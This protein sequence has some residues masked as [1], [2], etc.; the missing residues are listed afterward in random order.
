[1]WSEENRDGGEEEGKKGRRRTL[2]ILC[3]DGRVFCRLSGPGFP[4]DS[5]YTLKLHF[6]DMTEMENVTNTADTACGKYIL[7]V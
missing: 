3:I 2:S 1:M 7:L 6:I 4:L 5:I